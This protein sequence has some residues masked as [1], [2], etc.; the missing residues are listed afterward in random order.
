MDHA[1]Q[2]DVDAIAPPTRPLFDRLH[3]LVFEVSPDAEVVLS[4]AMPTYVVGDRRLHVGAWAHGVSL[5]GWD[6]GRDAGL[7]TRAWVPAAGA[8][9]G[10]SGPAA[11]AHD[12]LVEDHHEGRADEQPDHHARRG[13]GAA[14]LQQVGG[15]HGGAPS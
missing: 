2:D 12:R 9:A 6:A 8:F 1:V 3:R 4:Y 15:G 14:P 5:F 13:G 7:E 11:G 10:A